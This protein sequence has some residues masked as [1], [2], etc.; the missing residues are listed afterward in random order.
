MKKLQVINNK[1]DYIVL[2]YNVPHRKT[3]DTLLMLKAKG[4]KK[5]LVYASPMHYKKV[6]SPIYEHRPPLMMDIQPCD[7]SNNL[8]FD[9]Y[10]NDGYEYLEKNEGLVILLCGAGILPELAIKNNIIINS[11]PGYIPNVRGLDSL[12]WA[13]IN[14]QKIGVTTHI[15]GKE[16]DAGEIIDR[17]EVSVYDNDTFHALAQRVYE[18]EI[19]MLVEAIEH[20]KDEH[21]VTTAGDFVLHKRMPKDIE[22]T[23]LLKFEEYKEKHAICIEK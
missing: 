8:G 3:Y 14:N 23:L 13:I 22:E 20:I 7:L 4:Y 18:Q 16:V 2:T 17:Q 6:F 12:K 10:E 19:R 5:I 11:H 21:K 9:Y 15:L 1:Y